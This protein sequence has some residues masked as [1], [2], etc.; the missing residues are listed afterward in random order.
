MIQLT[1]SRFL[2]DQRGA[3]SIEYAIIASGIA[4]AIIATVTIL[5]GSVLT[6]WTSVAAIFN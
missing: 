6:M 4:G 3:T 1:I 5:G 2:R